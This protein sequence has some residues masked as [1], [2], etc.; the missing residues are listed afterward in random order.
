MQHQKIFHISLFFISFFLAG[1]IAH[2]QTNTD[3]YSSVG[4]GN[5]VNRNFDRS[6]GMGSAGISLASP[7]YIYDENPASLP[8]LSN[9]YFSME[10][11]GNL[12]GMYYTGNP[13]SYQST[14]GT[15]SFTSAQ[16][17]IERFVLAVKPTSFWGAA[18]GLKQFSSSNY[19]FTQPQNV[20][21]STD[22]VNTTR[23]G[24]GGI[25]QV[26]FSN[27]IQLNK[28]FSVGITA[29]Y[30]FG[31]MQDEKDILGQNVFGEQI[32]VTNLQYYH[33]FYFN[34]G[35]QYMAML[36]PKWR[37]GIGAIASNKTTLSGTNHLTITEGDADV[38]LPTPLVNDSITAAMSYFRLPIMYGAG[39]S[40]IYDDKLTFA[41]DY[42]AQNWGS[43]Q[44]MVPSSSYTFVNSR[45]ISAGVEYTKRKNIAIPNTNSIIPFDKYFYQIGGYYGNEYLEIRGKQLVNAGITLGVGSNSLK[46][47]LG[48]MF[49]LSIGTRGTTA[50]QLIKED[51]FQL[52]VTITYE[53]FWNR[54][55]LR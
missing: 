46:T 26:F 7:R 36:S 14:T 40:L 41:V 17:Q 48:Y 27:G 29:S 38:S 18:V 19:Y 30:L 23:T 9:H 22:I 11:S 43:V 42:K 12:T 37:I 13:L 54:F 55:K 20:I 4:I 47:G 3:P 15:G 53:D 44:N 52:G 8:K 6:A 33:R 34:V 32:N 39:I 49:N 25:N 1:N 45:Q 28:N 21:G 50:N 51:Y 35:A 16:F 24:S 5:I 10:V 31:S 2:A